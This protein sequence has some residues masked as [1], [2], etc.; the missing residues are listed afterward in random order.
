M[1]ESGLCK[2]VDE[3]LS[4]ELNTSYFKVWFI[5]FYQKLHM[6]ALQDFS[7][8][9]QNYNYMWGSQYG[10]LGELQTGMIGPS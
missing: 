2:L 10:S 6:E 5:L 9:P 1:N 7:A 8:L 3:N 4:N